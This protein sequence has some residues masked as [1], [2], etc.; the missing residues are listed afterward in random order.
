MVLRD[1]T[2]WQMLYETAARAHE[3][4]ALDVADLDLANRCESTQERRR[5]RHHR[6]AAPPPASCHG[7]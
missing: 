1:K 2:L 6:L 7:C 3:I 4:L 5:R